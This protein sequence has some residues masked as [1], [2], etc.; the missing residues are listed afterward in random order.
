MS[1]FPQSEAKPIRVETDLINFEVT[2]TDKKGNIVRGLKSEDFQIFE[3]GVERKIDFFEPIKNNGKSRPLAVVFAL[4]VSGSMTEQEIEK[5][6]FVISRFIETLADYRSQ[7]AILTFGMRV[8]VLLPFTNNPDK[9]RKA[10]LKLEH[11]RDG[12]STHAYDAVDTAIRMLRRQIPNQKNEKLAR[13]IVVL[14]TDG[15]PVGDL[16]TP[17]TV[18]ERANTAE[19]TIYSIILPSYSI[20]SRNKR[21]LL[22]PLEA[23][24]IIEKTGGRTFYPTEQELDEIFRALSDEFTGSYVLAFYPS[25]ESK[26]DGRFREVKIKIKQGN[27]KIRQNR[28]G[29]KFPIQ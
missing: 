3:N 19:V 2:V 24:G 13:K 12:L 8:K 26:R 23:S 29:Y 14:I 22:T 1:T 15:F 4:D 28:L 9:I 21:P 25:E 7:F 20:F 17:E 18:I 11:E 5:L 6:K 27:Y 16:V 10:I